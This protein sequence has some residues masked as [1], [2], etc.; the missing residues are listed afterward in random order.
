MI[1][2]NIIVIATDHNGIKQKKFL[3]NKLSKD[4]RIIDLGP[5]DDLNKVDYTDYSSQLSTIISSKQ[6]DFGILICGTGVGMSMVS[7]KYKNVR[8]ALVHNVV[9][10]INSKDHNDANV[11]C[12]G[13]WIN[14][15]STNFKLAK[16]WLDRKFGEGRHVKRVEKIEPIKDKQKLIFTNGVFDILHSG[17]IELLKFAKSLG[18][19]L[20]VGINS[21][22]STRKYKGKNRPI[23]N[24]NDRKA[25]LL[26]LEV[27]DEVI[28]F[29]DLNPTNLIN[30]I[31]PNVVVRGSEFTAD[32]VRNRDNISSEIK[33]KIFP[34]KKGYSTTRTIKKIRKKTNLVEKNK[35]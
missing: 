32:Q 35:N 13:S 8:A 28:I 7:N 16:Y 21:D 2:R 3:C 5:Y 12:L 25:I 11:L 14:S 19:K 23:N 31:K 4:Y 30:N 17:H 26:Q 18:H 1:N 10:A 24:Q 22:K 33:I 27:V 29:D 15:P 20:V 6:A 34:I 9:S